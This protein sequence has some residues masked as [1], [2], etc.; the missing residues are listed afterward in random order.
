[1]T[2]RSQSSEKESNFA[3]CTYSL[4]KLVYQILSI[5]LNIYFFSP[6]ERV[7][8]KC[9]TQCLTQYTYMLLNDRYSQQILFLIPT[10]ENIPSNQRVQMSTANFLNDLPRVE[11]LTQI[12]SSSKCIRYRKISYLIYSVAYVVLSISIHVF[13]ILGY[14][15]DFTEIQFLSYLSVGIEWKA[16]FK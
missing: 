9:P 10:E 13:S 6:L 12:R 11:H 14:S 2:H 3:V 5:S 4:H 8:I 7:D 15:R 16:H 1:M